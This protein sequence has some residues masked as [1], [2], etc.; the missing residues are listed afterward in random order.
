MQEATEG[1][2]DRTQHLMH[3]CSST[4]IQCRGLDL[5]AARVQKLRHAVTQ[6]ETHV[7][8]LLKQ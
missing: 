3:L 1:A 2:V 5:L 6:L 8:A 7:N 4:A